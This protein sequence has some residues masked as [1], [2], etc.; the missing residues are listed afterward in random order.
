MDFDGFFSVHS[1]VWCFYF[2]YIPP[3]AHAE[4][5]VQWIFRCIII[6]SR[7]IFVRFIFFLL[8]QKKIALFILTTEINY[9]CP[10]KNIQKI[11]HHI[12]YACS[13][14][15][16]FFTW[17]ILAHRLMVV[18]ASVQ[19][20]AFKFSKGLVMLRFIK[21]TNGEC[22]AAHSRIKRHI[23]TCTT[24][25]DTSRTPIIMAHEILMN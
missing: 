13:V 4:F 7:G 25:T 6:N 3:S 19:C 23:K 17:L 9:H 8:Q 24:D 20:N 2:L 11:V 10:Q 1:T 14:R 15:M 18:S 16:H 22:Y 21:F 5:A 12:L